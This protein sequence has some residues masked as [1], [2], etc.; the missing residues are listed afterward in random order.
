MLIRIQREKRYRRETE[1]A[2][3]AVMKMSCNYDKTLEILSIS[4]S[5]NVKQQVSKVYFQIRMAYIPLLYQKLYI[6]LPL[7]FVILCDKTAEQ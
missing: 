2:M 5:I 7:Y 6:F 3:K 4:V 1:S